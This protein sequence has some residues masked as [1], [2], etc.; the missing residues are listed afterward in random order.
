MSLS[1]K[2]VEMPPPTTCSQ[3]SLRL[4]M[5]YSQLQRQLAPMYLTL[6]PTPSMA[7]RPPRTALNRA[8]AAAGRSCSG[9]VRS[10]S[11]SGSG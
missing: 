4:P 2:V 8:A 1:V 9:A 5:P 11:A 7:S 10:G 3:H 6:S